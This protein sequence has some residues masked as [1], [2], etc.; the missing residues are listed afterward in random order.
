MKCRDA[1]IEQEIRKE[2]N[3]REKDYG[4]LRSIIQNKD[5]VQ[6]EGKGKGKVT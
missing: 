4:R 1:R 5:E 3:S 2:K 6:N